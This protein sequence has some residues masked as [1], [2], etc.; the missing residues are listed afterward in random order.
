MASELIDLYS[1]NLVGT[2]PDQDIA[3]LAVLDAATH[4]GEESAAALSLATDGP[5]GQL[6]A[7]GPELVRMARS[8]WL[9]QHPALAAV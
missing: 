6:I 5:T 2:Y 1:Y 7:Q 4:D 3:L 8:R 9:T